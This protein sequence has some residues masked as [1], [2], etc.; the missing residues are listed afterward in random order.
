M[1][2]IK[3][4][5]KPNK[6]QVIRV[7]LFSLTFIAL[8]YKC[9]LFLGFTLNKNSYS[10]N[11]PLG[12]SNAS[13]FFNYYGAFIL[14]FMCFY[15][16]FKNKGR[17][18]YLI[19]INAFLTLLILVDLWYFRGFN[20]VPSL[21]IVKQTA[22]LDNLSG[23]VF[24]MMSPLDLLFVIDIIIIAIVGIL[25]RNIYDLGKRRVPT[26]FIVFLLCNA[27]IFHVPFTT[28]VLKKD[29]SKSY[30]FGMY[31]PNDTTH[32]FSPIGY[33][34]FNVYTV[35]RDSKPLK[36]TEKDK[37]EIKQWFEDKKENLP[38][39]K[40]KAMFKDKNLIII[41]VE[42]LESF[43]INQKVNGKEITP[44]LNRILNNSIYFPNINEQV[45]EGTSSDSDLMVNTSVYPLRQ[46]STF[47]SYPSN[48]YN[49]LPKLMEEKGY[50]TIAIHPDKGAFW[51][52]ME[53]LKGIG[54]QNF[55]DYY[56]FN[57]DETIGLGLSDGSYFKQIVPMLEKQPKPFYSFMV[58][59][60]SHGPFDLP[61]EYRELG[62]PEELDKNHLGGYFESVHYTDKQIGMFLDSL[63][64][65][66]I[67]DNSVVAITGDH[68]GVH[69]YYNDKLAQLKNPESWWLEVS[70]HI[71]LILYEK[72]FKEPEKLE[73]TGGQIDTM[74]TLAYIMGIEEDKY[75][76]T[77]MGRNLLKTNKDF[78]VLA[79]RSFVGKSEEEK[80]HAIKGL[81][82]ADKILKSNYFKK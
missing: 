52:W 67:L 47:F 11:F 48:T 36:L 18:W 24:S 72:N 51:N 34:V 28:H 15:F 45:N 77:A 23:S 29:H 38:D 43:V 73:V 19:G 4:P 9:V 1:L 64:K 59:L 27:F 12:Y 79:N 33:H 6:N 56:S 62:L 8:I 16:L 39:N 42:S 82:I 75:I 30:L 25:F 21:I 76:N 40:Y 35:W 17:L 20:T 2:V 74:P 60:T 10:L 80:D 7:S 58:T 63:D 70:N 81:D 46:G 78:A 66:G 61:P 31:D 68:T 65:A 57:I 69:K 5:L 44:N 32:F 50:S 53:G 41:Q 14:A 37:E 55:A 3:K 54:F 49:S 22:N 26:F 71:P 13:Y